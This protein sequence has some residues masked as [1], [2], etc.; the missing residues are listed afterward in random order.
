[1]EQ[2]QTIQTVIE[3]FSDIYSSRQEINRLLKNK[4]QNPD[5]RDL[6]LFLL[7]RFQDYHRYFPFFSFSQIQSKIGFQL[8]FNKQFLNL[9]KSYGIFVIEQIKMALFL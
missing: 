4:I 9:K 3:Y 5:L 1:M 7:R 2:L 8:I 6:L